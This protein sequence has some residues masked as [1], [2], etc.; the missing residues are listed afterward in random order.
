[1][2]MTLRCSGMLVGYALN[3][4]PADARQRLAAIKIRPSPKGERLQWVWH[5]LSAVWRQNMSA[6]EALS[7]GD[8]QA[9]AGSMMVFSFRGLPAIRLL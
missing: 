6:V 5:V 8:N 4:L 7:T 3:G 9:K 2:D 1:M